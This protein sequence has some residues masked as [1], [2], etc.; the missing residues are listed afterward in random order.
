MQQLC[1]V[2]WRALTWEPACAV[3][4]E[5]TGL[6]RLSDGR[7]MIFLERRASKGETEASF[8]PRLFQ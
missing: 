6:H 1:F 2:L 8:R 5:R 3:L 7:V 4:P